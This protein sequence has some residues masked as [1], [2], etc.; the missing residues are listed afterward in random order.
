M[1]NNFTKANNAYLAYLVAH[2][3]VND[4]KP[5]RRLTKQEKR[6]RMLRKVKDVVIYTVCS[7]AIMTT[8]VLISCA[9]S[10]VASF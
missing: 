5:V 1:E 7:I 3:P 8:L 9:D 10:I 6:Q 2:Y 4:Y